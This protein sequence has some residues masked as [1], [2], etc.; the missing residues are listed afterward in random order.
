MAQSIGESLFQA[1]KKD[2]IKA[3][4]ALKEKAQCGAYR[5]GRFPVLSLLYLYKSR[6]IL[7]AYEEEFLKITNFEPLREPVEISKRFS[8]K[9]GKC[10]RLY[11]NETVSPLE[12]LLI[13]DKTR[14]LKRVYPVTKPS[15]AVKG[16]LKSI[17][18][19]KYSLNVEFEGDN[20]KIDRRPLSYREKKNIAT[21]CLCSVLAVTVAVG[22]PVTT[23]ALM[24]K[25]VEGEVTK[26]SHIDFNSTKEYTLKR[27]ITL[28]DNYS[29]EKVNCKIIGE[30]K[31]LIFGKGA[32]LGEFN[33]KIS[34]LTIESSGDAVFCTVTQS[35]VIENVTVNVN[36]AYTAT[37]STA[38]FAVNNYGTID[39]VTLNVSGT[40]N[41]FAP[42]SEAVSELT[43][44][45][46]VLNNVYRT[47][48][49]IGTI[50]NCTVNYSDFSLKGEAE[51]NAV[52]GGIAGINNGYLQDCTVTGEINSDTFD[53]AGVCYT[54]NGM[55]S[56]EVNKAN[57]SQ[58][59]ANTG[60]NPITCGI[61]LNN[62][63]AV[64]NCENRGA[65]S[66]VST[67]GQFEATEGSESTAS[68]AGIAYVSRGSSVS[69]K[70]C[71]NYGNIEST[72]AYRD[73]YAAGVCLSS[74]GGIESCTNSGSVTVKADN[75]RGTYAGGITALAYGYVYK[76]VNE[77]AVTANCNG[78]AY[79]G[80]LS[81]Y[82]YSQFLNCISKGD[83]TV[84]AQN[85]YAGGIF[86][87]SIPT[88]G[89]DLFNVY[90]YLGT[91][92]YCISEGNI[93]VNL[94]QD[95]SIAY[96]G[97]IAGYVRE[98]QTNSDSVIYRGG[99]TYCYFTGK[100]TSE[101]SNFGNIIGV[102]DAKIYEI[103]CFDKNYYL[104][105]SSIAFG[106]IIT[107]DGSLTP[108]EDKGA[109]SAKTEDI[110]NSEE[111]KSIL[112]NLEK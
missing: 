90:Y 97:G 1:I 37:K 70:N 12:M 64:E 31:K 100:C 68:A 35:A 58:T 80:G 75:G 61:V 104:E 87:V 92:E 15:E 93:E 108:V 86:G 60:W 27:D 17:Y 46:I 7:S 101:I 99:I 18:S 33:G 79:A 98:A 38:F 30:G 8:A 51:A 39:G 14:R 62:T 24:P 65:I 63:Y 22:V 54:N 107:E 34:D 5:L 44:G 45:G 84:T 13:L 85:V 111:Y 103:D 72:A 43:F 36:T 41:A 59:S 25:P 74:S 71:N 55:L 20:I 95:D 42:S 56:N 52:F 32:T 28:P 110:K 23:V 96:A 82:S 29:V 69:I 3:F 88:R 76:C 81:A 2:D 49:A 66:A 77:G 91:A 105:N 109:T 48:T 112:T 4:N 106:A 11:L 102:C 9:A 53:L 83:L 47:N 16:R 89:Y 26:L 94:T 19:I 40:L 6:K 78:S 10:L 73:A 67:C 57:L 50:K 21:V